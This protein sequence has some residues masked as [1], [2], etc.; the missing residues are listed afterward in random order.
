MTR[1]ILALLAL[2]L[3]IPAAALA[4]DWPTKEGDFIARDVA[5]KSGEKLAEVRLHYTTL[6]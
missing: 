5:F 2:V 3:M 4:A 6:P 1:T